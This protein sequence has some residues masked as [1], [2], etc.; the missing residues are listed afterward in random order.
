MCHKI[1]VFR[2]YT[3]YIFQLFENLSSDL[4]QKKR[5]FIRSYHYISLLTTSK[6]SKLACE[7]SLW[8]TSSDFIHILQCFTVFREMKINKKESE[9]LQFPHEREN[10]LWQEQTSRSN[11]NFL[12]LC[13]LCKCSLWVWSNWH[14]PW[15]SLV[16]AADT[17]CHNRIACPENTK[18]LKNHAPHP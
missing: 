5:H 10:K 6:R 4:F 11:N 3:L 12:V 8:P 13:R 1:Y 16:S 7:H 17:R 9:N 14:C 18:S 2:F 15:L